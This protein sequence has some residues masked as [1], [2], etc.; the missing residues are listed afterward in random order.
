MNTHLS[1]NTLI[2]IA[3]FCAT[4]S[5]QTNPLEVKLCDDLPLTRENG[6]GRYKE[7]NFSFADSIEAITYLKKHIPDL[8]D[9]ANSIEEIQRADNYQLGYF[10]SLHIAEGTA[11]KAQALLNPDDTTYKQD[12]CKF[13]ERTSIPD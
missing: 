5:A 12:F 9:S 4:A 7:E 3:F 2:I 11:L 1:I 6:S 8:L 13:L 10:H